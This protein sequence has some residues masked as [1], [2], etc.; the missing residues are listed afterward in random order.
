MDS[1]LTITAVWTGPALSGTRVT[2]SDAYKAGQQMYESTAEISPL[3][4]DDDG[5]YTCTATVTAAEDTEYILPATGN[6]DIS[7]TVLGKL[8]HG[9]PW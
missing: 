4:G 7:I 8:A 3:A 6:S 2:T 1:A 9:F 5:S